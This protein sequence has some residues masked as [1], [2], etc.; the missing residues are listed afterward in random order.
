MVKYVNS[1]V[2][3]PS[4]EEA[5]NVSGKRVSKKSARYA[6]FEINSKRRKIDGGDDHYYGDDDDS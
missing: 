6:N 1:R 3:T 2:T 5:A 4:K